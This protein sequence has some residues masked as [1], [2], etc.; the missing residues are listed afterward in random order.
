MAMKPDWTRVSETLFCREPDRVPI[1]D[2][3]VDKEIKEAFLGK[4]V[5]SLKDDIEFSVQAGYDFYHIHVDLK[6]MVNSEWIKSNT[7]T[8]YKDGKYVRR[9]APEH[10]GVIANREEFEKFP[11]WEA[12][13]FDFSV[14]EKARE[15]LPDGMEIVGGNS[16]VMEQ[17]WQMM[18]YE[19][20]AISIADNKELVE[21][22]LKKIA[23]LCVKVFEKIASLK[24][25]GALW[26]CDDIAYSSGLMFNP[27][28]WRRCVLPYI[29]K[30]G[31]IA[32]SKKVPFLYHSDGNISAILKDLIDAGVNAIHPVEPKAMDIEALKEMYGKRLSF[33]GNI[34]LAWTLTRG[35]VSDVE[36]EV[37][38][39]I[40]KI[41]PGGGYCVGSGNSVTNY[42]PLENY[43]AMNESTFK[44]GKYPINI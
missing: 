42:V 14:F 20:F 34:D 21:A 27:E 25:I 44:Y 23:G 5:E 9:W 2:G 1:F 11:W 41:A 8:L 4:K 40:A 29:R 26:Y 32:K 17:A 37:K 38:M 18:G 16:G 6:E 30:M 10:T 13:D 3:W 33:M 12:E 15:L 7:D 43:I 22:L 19:T 35:T 36:K 24:N 28:L 31:D 39:R